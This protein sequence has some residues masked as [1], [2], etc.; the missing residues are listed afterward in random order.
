MAQLKEGR[1]D[2]AYY[3][4]SIINPVHRT[5]SL[6]DVLSGDVN[7][8]GKLP[9][10]IPYALEDGPIRSERQFP[11]VEVP[12]PD[13]PRGV[14]K[15]EQEYTE[16]IF[17]GYRWYDTKG[18]APRYPFGYGLSYTQFTYGPARLG[19]KTMRRNGSVT[20]SVDV[21]NSGTRAGAETVQLYVSDKEASVPRPAK[22]LKGFR[23]VFLQ[24]GETAT[25]RF[26]LTKDDL[27][28][29]DAQA[30]AWKAEPGEFELLVGASSADIR[31]RASFT[32]R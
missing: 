4:Y 2:M 17:V 6:A 31:A 9:F 16:G 3:L 27:S 24:P 20:L 32:L 15:Y 23:K 18:I 7:P 8:S 13:V 10:T 30:H 22:E 25:V 14:K 1:N 12:H 19:A 21:T 26:T 28:W 5:H 11:G 29:F